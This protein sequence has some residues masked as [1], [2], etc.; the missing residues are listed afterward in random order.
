[1]RQQWEG[2]LGFDDLGCVLE[3]RFNIAVFRASR[4]A[5]WWGLSS[6]RRRQLFALREV[7]GAA[8]RSDRTLVP[9]DLQRFACIVRQP[10]VVGND[11][12]T[13]SPIHIRTG[14]G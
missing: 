10:P 5:A 8:L 2:I 7:A 13:R 1:M 14:W 11:G 6:L 4:T 9:N 12:D 3:R